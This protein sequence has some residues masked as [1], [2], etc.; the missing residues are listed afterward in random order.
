MGA[1][2]GVG[3]EVG[4]GSTSREDVSMSAADWDVGVGELRWRKSVHPVATT[5]AIV[6][7]SRRGQYAKGLVISI[8][9]ERVHGFGGDWTEPFEA[10]QQALKPSFDSLSHK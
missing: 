1:G 4:V 7:N 3:V 2:V 6:D 10:G 5:R 8:G 9:A